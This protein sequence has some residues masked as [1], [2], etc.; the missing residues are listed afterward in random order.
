[1]KK[2]IGAFI[3][4]YSAFAFSATLSPIQLLNPAG[5]TS[6][7]AI[8]ST[9][10]SSAP[11]W[12]GIGLN[13][14]A[15]IAA[16]TVLANAT[17]TSASPTAFSMPS[18]SSA[19]SVLQYTSGTGFTC[20]S[21]FLTSPTITTPNIVGTAT[22]NNAAAGSVGEYITSNVAI[23]SA[24]SL[25]NVTAANITSISVTA[26]D[27]DIWGAVCTNPAGTTVQQ[28]STAG[29]S[30]TSAT[31]QNPGLSVYP[32]SAPAGAVICVPTPILRISL[33][34][35]TTYF[36]VFSSGFTTSTNAAYGFIGA[37]RRR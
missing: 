22:N 15:A 7:Q 33:A 4:L 28:S 21:A 13:G 23:G 11:A 30:S 5:S 27:W 31:F 34:S 20:S 36:L 8:V 19:A 37:R 17:G 18:C 24:I 35:T 1:M 6:G 26:G 29:I 2:I 9:G 12:G 3:A 16:N 32:F 25:T 10:A 14:I